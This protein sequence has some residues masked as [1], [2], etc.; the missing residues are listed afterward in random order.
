MPTGRAESLIVKIYDVRATRMKLVVRDRNVLSEFTF[1]KH[2]INVTHIS[3]A[4]GISVEGEP[5]CGLYTNRLNGM[6]AAL[7]MLVT[8]LDPFRRSITP[9]TKNPTAKINS[10]PLITCKD[11]MPKNEKPNKAESGYHIEFKAYIP[12]RFPN[13]GTTP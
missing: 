12:W 6:A 2:R 7:M 10:I 8:A 5:R 9:P 13:P 11:W 1:S 3:N 4:T